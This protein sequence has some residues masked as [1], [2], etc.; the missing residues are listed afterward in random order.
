M[1]GTYIKGRIEA[2]IAEN[3]GGVDAYSGSAD[4]LALL[5]ELEHLLEDERACL[6][7]F[8]RKT[9][10]EKVQEFGEKAES[11]RDNFDS[12]RT[13]LDEKAQEI[14]ALIR[15]SRSEF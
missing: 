2:I 10:K 7:G 5:T 3:K 6:T 11:F 12:Y 1:P 14:M 15:Q 8:Q 4:M 13:F 9:I